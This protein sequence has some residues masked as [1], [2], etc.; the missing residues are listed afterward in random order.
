MKYLISDTLGF[1]RELNFDCVESVVDYVNT[2][3]LIFWREVG[4]L[5]ND[6]V[7]IYEKREDDYYI[8]GHVFLG[9]GK[10]EKEVKSK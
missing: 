3:Y 6:R 7:D 8:I 1:I 4:L 9:T 5:S 2:R 10:F